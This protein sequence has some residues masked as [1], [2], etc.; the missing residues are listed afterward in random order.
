MH[1]Y[2]A[3]DSFVHSHQIFLNNVCNKMRIWPF[4]VIIENYD[5]YKK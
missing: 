5:F 1:M 2:W 4:N 3:L